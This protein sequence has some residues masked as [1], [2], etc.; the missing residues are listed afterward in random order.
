M[1]KRVE[2]VAGLLLAVAVGL[3]FW[4]VSGSREPVFEGRPLSNWLDHHVASSSAN[5][6]Y[7]SPGWKKADEAIRHIGTNAIPTLLEMIRASDRPAFVIKVMN[8]ARSL[9]L[10][11][12][13]YR[14][15]SL[16]HE[17][18]EYAFKMLGTN[19]ASAVPELSRIYEQNISASSQRCAALALG[20][21]G[22]GAQAALPALISNFA[23]T[24]ADVRFYAVSA[25]LHIGGEPGVVVPP[26]ASA[27]KDSNEHVRWNALVALS[28]Y[29]VRARAAVPEILNM[30]NDPGMLSSNR[31]TQQVERALWSIAPE[32]VGKP[33][34]V[35]DV[36][37][38]I[39]NGMTTQALKQGLNGTRHTLIR[40]GHPVPATT[41]WSIDSRPR[42]TLYR[43][44]GDSEDADHFL[45][46]FEVLDLPASDNLN[47]GIVC[48]IVDGK[49]VLCA[50]DYHRDEFL[51]FRRVETQAVK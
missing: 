34:V 33:L 48:V 30:F 35:E 24:D 41:Y 21:I 15:A 36:T 26:L 43:G 29:G 8:K 11:R 47:V 49:I 39:A 16:R 13:M 4:R 27:L 40:A 23:H 38:I 5:P 14:Y 17:E 37:P 32:K 22:R 18:A 50:K 3:V 19:A 42:L 12:S 9:G 44:P 45:G 1:S 20:H 7:G 28:N 6:P 31:F 2:I 46:H 25:V 51:E 10:M